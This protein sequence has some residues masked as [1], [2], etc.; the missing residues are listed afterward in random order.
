MEEPMRFDWI[1]SLP[2]R[3]AEVRDWIHGAIT[4]VSWSA[5]A[6]I[7]ARAQ[8]FAER[9]RPVVIIAGVGLAFLL[10]VDT[11]IDYQKTV[12]SQRAAAA[13]LNKET[14][15]PRPPTWHTRRCL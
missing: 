4:N 6:T 9:L 5:P 15:K 13:P 2:A 11:G 12:S 10:G 14:V 3:L 8:Q 7:I 1:K